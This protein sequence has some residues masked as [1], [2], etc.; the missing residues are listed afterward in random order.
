MEGGKKP[1]VLGL[2]TRQ[3]AIGGEENEERGIAWMCCSCQLPG[4]GGINV[5]T[6]S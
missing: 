5:N 6:W 1:F 2:K 3:L 4:G